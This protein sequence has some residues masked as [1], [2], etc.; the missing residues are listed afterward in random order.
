MSAVNQLGRLPNPSPEAKAWMAEQQAWKNQTSAANVQ[1]AAATPKGAGYSSG[2]KAGAAVKN[3]GKTLGS[4]AVPAILVDTAATVHD[5][6]TSDY[7]KRFAFSPNSTEGVAGLARDVGVRALGA[8][9]D[10]ANSATFGLAGKYLFADKQGGAVDAS[11]AVARPTPQQAAYSNEGNNYK[12]VGGALQPPVVSTSQPAPPPEAGSNA[13]LALQNPAGRVTKTVD[14]NGR[15]SYSGQNVS[16]DVSFVGRDGKPLAGAPGGTYNEGFIGGGARQQL[17]GGIGSTAGGGLPLYNVGGTGYSTRE[18]AIMAANIRDGI[19]PMR[20]LNGAPQ[21]SIMGNSGA[22][23]KSPGQKYMEDAM[24]AP[25]T[26]TNLTQR[27]RDRIADTAVRMDATAQ[28]GASDAA[29]LNLQGQELAFRQQDAA[30]RLAM[31]GQ[32]LGVDMARFNAEQPRRDAELVKLGIGNQEA[33]S[34]IDARDAYMN[35][36]DGS[37]EQKSALK[38]LQTL[39]GKFGKEGEWDATR[40]K[41]GVD[42]NG[43]PIEGIARMNKATGE[44]IMPDQKATGAKPSFEVG[45]TYPRT[46]ADGTTVN[47]RFMGNGK[48]DEVK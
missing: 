39:S 13:A 38:R 22:Q 41:I 23:A 45:K 29:R 5:T 18:N 48:W 28:Q 9:S 24:N 15:V 17:A 7:E 6:P 43:N 32:R 26:L 12:A 8:A 3:L 46:L 37:S 10:M 25:R 44:V 27:Q 30:N 16:G 40:V 31:D 36:K 2:Y 21:V 11:Q 1:G 33:K 14:A 35:A 4:V 19:D 47:A 42:A 34:L 20:G